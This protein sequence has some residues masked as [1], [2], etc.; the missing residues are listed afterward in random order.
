M[1][2]KQN[3]HAD[4]AKKYNLHKGIIEVICN[5]PFVF[6]SKVIATDSDEKTIMFPFFGKLK[7]R[8]QFIGEKELIGINREPWA[9]TKYIKAKE[10]KDDSKDKEIE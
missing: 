2:R 6:A 1:R 7:L 8:K 9:L 10:K 3:I 5:S 4:L